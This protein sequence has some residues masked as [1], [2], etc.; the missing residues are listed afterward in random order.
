MQRITEMDCIGDLRV[1]HTEHI[2][3]CF[4]TNEW[5]HFNLQSI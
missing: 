2:S 5:V 3:I 4:Y 1:K